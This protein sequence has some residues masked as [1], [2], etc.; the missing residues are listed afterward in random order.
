M[1]TSFSN[2]ET[3]DQVLLEHWLTFNE[4]G[5]LSHLLSD[6]ITQ[7]WK[8]CQAYQINNTT[9]YYP[10]L[11]SDV[12]IKSLLQEN[13]FLIYHATRYLKY[14]FSSL[15]AIAPTIT[16]S[17]HNSEVLA[18]LNNRFSKVEKI[19]LLPG[20]EWSESICGTNGIGT[21]AVIQKPITIFG[22]E[23]FYQGWHPL[24]C[25]SSPILDPFTNQL[26]GIL[27]V[28]GQ[29]DLVALH[30][31][32]MVQSIA[33]LIENSIQDY[34]QFSIASNYQHQFA[35]GNPIVILD[36]SLVIQYANVQAIKDL[37]LSRG[38]HLPFIIQNKIDWASAISINEDFEDKKGKSWQL[39]S[40]PYFINSRVLGRIVEF[41]KKIMI[42]NTL[43]VPPKRSFVFQDIITQDPVL[44]NAKVLAKEAANTDFS[45]LI[46]GE[47]GT[48]KELFAHAIHQASSRK[49]QPLVTINCGA[50]PK[51]LIA[52]ELFGYVEGAFT[53]AIK[54]G[55]E[56]K[57]SAANNGTIFLDEIGELPLELQP[58]LLRILEDKLVYKLGAVKG[59]PINTRVIAATNKNLKEA[60]E[61][62]T[63]RADL[64]YR[65]NVLQ[66]D[67]PPLRSRKD[68]IVLLFAHFLKEKQY[69]NISIHQEVIQRLEN[70]PWHG[71]IRELMNCFRKLLFN[72]QTYPSGG[73]ITI[74]HFPKEY[75]EEISSI[76][77][78][79]TPTNPPLTIQQALELTN[80]NKSKAANLLGISRMTLYRKMSENDKKPPS[81]TL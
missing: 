25:T 31:T 74:D 28:S 30:N 24:V 5:K 23:H 69:T 58:Y 37:Q 6:T 72:Y 27:T 48:G 17:N 3:Y 35:S 64:Y 14:L 50:I 8:R 78:S 44:N 34:I 49:Q 9:R 45:V 32:S 61:K 12:H 55:K 76:D 26:L 70:L 36:D 54:G 19:N 43:E 51:D 59:E 62:G 22:H 53:N 13:D 21:S 65:L 56:G 1:V 75:E 16:L 33:K 10:S 40:E 79:S 46:L 68:D 41:K 47:S 57:F 29:K 38:S 18:V 63:F 11:K 81:A 2:Y 66:I 73:T 80:G 20:S 52:S 67:I 39:T 77:L 4:S 60:V 15:E 42:V 7:S 71:N